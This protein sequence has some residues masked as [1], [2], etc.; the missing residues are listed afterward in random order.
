MMPNNRDMI[1]MYTEKLFIQHGR[2]TYIRILVGHNGPRVRFEVAQVQA[3]FTSN[4]MTIAVDKL[5]LKITAPAG[6][7][8]R[9][10]TRI[11]N[12]DDW[13]EMIN[14]H[15]LMKEKAF[16]IEVRVEFI[17]KGDQSKSDTRAVHIHCDWNKVFVV[18][19]Q[20]KR[21]F[22]KGAKEF[23]MGIDLRCILVF[24]K[25]SVVTSTRREAINKAIAKQRAFLKAL[26]V[27]QAY[28]ITNL[29]VW[30][31]GSGTTLRQV[32]MGIRVVSDPD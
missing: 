2:Y 14:V 8:L 18:R 28:G 4:K 31:Q 1:R 10:D 5:Q 17:K 32:I 30:D 23:P 13:A 7:M 9:A 6:W 25:R 11:W 29:D 24:D 16:T 21:I 26:V 12:W 3:I 22:A 15:P 27:T 19:E 20:M